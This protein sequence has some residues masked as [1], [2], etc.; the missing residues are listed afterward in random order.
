MNEKPKIKVIKK[1]EIKTPAASIKVQSRTKREAA[2]E[3]VS[4]VSNWVSDF[5]LRKRDETKAAIEKFLTPNPR[6]SES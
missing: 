2:R 3:V 6:P 1:N 4:T 5:Q